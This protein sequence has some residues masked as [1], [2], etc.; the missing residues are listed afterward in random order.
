MKLFIRHLKEQFI[1]FLQISFSLICKELAETNTTSPEVSKSYFRIY[2]EY[3]CSINF[4]AL[5]INFT[6]T[7][8]V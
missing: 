8:L 4:G 6:F 5:Q 2:V 1:R 3:F 7:F